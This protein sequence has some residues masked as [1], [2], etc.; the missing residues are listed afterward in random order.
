MQAGGNIGEFD[1]AAA[2][3]LVE[4]CRRRVPDGGE[5]RVL[6]R[7]R[8]IGRQRGEAFEGGAEHGAGLTFRQRDE[9][10][11]QPALDT[12]EWT[13]GTRRRAVSLSEEIG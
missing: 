11:H 4:H 9:C 5:R 8:R 7:V 12:P 2:D 3:R 13:G 10:I 1:G 6:R